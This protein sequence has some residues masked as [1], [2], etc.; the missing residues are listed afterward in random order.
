MN[1]RIS[2]TIKQLVP[3][4]Q[5]GIIECEVINSDYNSVLWDNIQNTCHALKNEYKI[6]N[7]NKI[8]AIEATRNAY[9]KLGKD[10][11]RYRPSAE[12][13]YRRIV[14]GLNLYQINTLV[15][16]INFASIR[17][18]YSINGFD[19]DKIAGNVEL[20]IG[21][22]NEPFEAIGR[23]HLNIEGMP[24]YRDILGAIGTPTSDSERIK[25]EL[26]TKKLL[27]IINVYNNE[28]LLD[29][30]LDQT[31]QLLVSFGCATQFKITKS[32]SN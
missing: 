27:L 12:A 15:D 8:A 2:E 17:S 21:V 28:N 3:H 29:L 16:I 25:I 23:G 24:V 22:A 20:G 13:L 14:R 4:M 9:K 6:E 11:N 7:I 30:S 10:P 19:A 1:I 26:S 32:S 18:G 5:L 31:Q